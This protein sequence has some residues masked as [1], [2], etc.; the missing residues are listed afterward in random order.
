VTTSKTLTIFIP[1]YNR[2]QHLSRQLKFLTSILC[3]INKGKILVNIIVSD[4]ASDDNTSLV[5]VQYENEFSWVASH[6]QPRNVGFDG[7]FE[8]LVSSELGDYVW[9]LGDDD[10]IHIEI[11]YL[12]HLLSLHDKPLCL[13][14]CTNGMRLGASPVFTVGSFEDG[15]N[16]VKGLFQFIS[17]WII[18]S[19]AY[20]AWGKQ[21]RALCLDDPHCLATLGVIYDYGFLILNMR[22]ISPLPSLKTYQDQLPLLSSTISIFWLR[23]KAAL[24]ALASKRDFSDRSMHL[25]R[26]WE[27]KQLLR[28][29]YI[30]LRDNPGGISGYEFDRCIDVANYFI[31]RKLLFA[32]KLMPVA[33]LATIARAYSRAKKVLSGFVS[34][35]FGVAFGPRIS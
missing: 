25:Y 19:S 17:S 20:C 15:L 16:R 34:R 28:S 22:C 10:L 8:Y 11:D 33:N 35:S 21:G 31:V 23:P 24:N 6:R 27:D 4:N 9:V 18:P 3:R 5:A 13:P 30:C 1:T 29:I 2:E 14:I 26:A 7:Q 12:L 32:I